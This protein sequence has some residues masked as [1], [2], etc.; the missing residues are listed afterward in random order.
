MIEWQDSI[1]SSVK[2]AK[3]E[4]KLVMIDFFNPQ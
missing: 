2:K 1:D 4:G 3:D